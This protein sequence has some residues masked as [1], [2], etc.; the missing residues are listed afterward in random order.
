MSLSDEEIE[1]LA[2]KILS[3]PFDKMDI[4]ESTVRMQELTGHLSQA[5]QKAVAMRH[6][7]MMHE[8]GLASLEASKLGR[9]ELQ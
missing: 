6:C 8:V 1:A 9:N 2:S 4:D 5:D 3:E 7:E